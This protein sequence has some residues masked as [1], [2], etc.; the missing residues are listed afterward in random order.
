MS[1][2]NNS[3]ICF[4]D[5]EFNAFDYNGQNDGYQEITE[6]GATV[7]NN[8]N[9]I[10]SFSRYCR[11]SHGHK[12]SRRCKK[13][14]GIT[15]EVLASNGVSFNTAVNEL[16]RFLKQHNVKRI[17]AFGDADSVELRRTAK[18]NNSGPE[19]VSVLKSIKDVY[20]QFRSLLSLHYVFS[21]SDIC[22]ICYVN[23]DAEG[24]AHN[25]LYDAEDTGKA[26]YNMRKGHINRQLLDEINAHKYNIKLYRNMRNIKLATIKP[27]PELDEAFI[28]NVNI[29]IDN[30]K[31]TIGLP[32]ALA[33]HDDM[34]RVMGRPDLEI[35]EGG[36]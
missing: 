14:T 21:L 35:G 19:V 11:L 23:H 28:N 30:A 6:I 34:M 7:F 33:L 4:L 22:R 26:F 3:N 29:V 18:L 31:K 8:G 5:T 36:L 1:Q 2:I 16:L 17:Y 27:V 15:Q 10:A 12:L 20:P 32:A 24:R 25:A 13:I 9:V